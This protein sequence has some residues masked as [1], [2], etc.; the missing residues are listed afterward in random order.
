M[1]FTAPSQKDVDNI[2]KH[3][4]ALTKVCD[5]YMPLMCAGCP[6]DEFCS[7]I[8]IGS[9]LSTAQRNWTRKMELQK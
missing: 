4:S 2:H 7:S 1:P 6:L 8:E 5:T 9:C 3:L